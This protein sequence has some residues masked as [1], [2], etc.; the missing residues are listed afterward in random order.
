MHLVISHDH[1]IVSLAD[2]HRMFAAEELDKQILNEIGIL[3]LKQF[4][5]EMEKLKMRRRK[6]FFL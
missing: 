6:L 3:D 2:F 5:S 4:R 1:R